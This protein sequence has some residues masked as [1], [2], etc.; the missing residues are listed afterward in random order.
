[1][2]I[3]RTEADI[4][5]VFKSGKVDALE[6]IRLE[7]IEML[8]ITEDQEIMDEKPKIEVENE[9]KVTS[10]LETLV[11]P[12]EVNFKYSKN[13]CN[14]CKTLP[15][16]PAQDLLSFDEL[17]GDESNIFLKSVRLSSNLTGQTCAV[18]N[19]TKL[20][21]FNFRKIIRFVCLTQRICRMNHQHSLT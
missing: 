18:L 10:N 6:K 2:Q 8:R 14:F 3:D 15:F 19:I 13:A 1:M 11:T 20:Q 16:K 12:L 9:E 17:F 7:M 21:N 5:S 4:K